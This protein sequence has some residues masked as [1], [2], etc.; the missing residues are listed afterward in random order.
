M[1]EFLDLVGKSLNAEYKAG[2]LPGRR[3]RE[4]LLALLRRW[5]L[6]DRHPFSTDVL[7]GGCRFDAVSAHKSGPR[8]IIRGYKIHLGPYGVRLHRKLVAALPRVNELYVV[9][10]NP[11]LILPSQDGQA[12]VIS[13]DDFSSPGRGG[14]YQPTSSHSAVL[15]EITYPYKGHMDALWA[16][17]W[18]LFCLGQH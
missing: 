11:K 17:T 5:V 12:G 2:R 18:R 10:S 7:I 8:I 14:S 3:A 4:I 9:T 15:H 13:F 6:Q 16:L 1:I